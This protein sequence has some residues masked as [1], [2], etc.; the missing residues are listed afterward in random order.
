M[1]S[2]VDPLPT[3]TADAYSLMVSVCKSAAAIDGRVRHPVPSVQV[4]RKMA[5]TIISMLETCSTDKGGC[6]PC[7]SLHPCT[8]FYDEFFCANMDAEVPADAI[9]E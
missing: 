2:N 6:L 9:S 8:R 3:A 7:P 4:R 1:M 5:P